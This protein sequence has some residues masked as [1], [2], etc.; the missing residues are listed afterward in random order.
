MSD[1][2][3]LEDFIEG[4]SE[5]EENKEDIIET[6]EWDWIPLSELIE[7]ILGKTPKRSEDQY[8]EE[9]DIKWASAKDIS[10]SY[11]RHIY[12][13][14]EK[15]T[16]AGKEA[17]NAK[18]MPEGTVVVTA[19]GTLGEVI[20]LGEP[21]TFNQSCYALRTN[22]ML[23]DDYLYYAWQYVFGQIEAISYGT[24]FDTITMKSF[25]DIEIPLPP[26]EIQRK[27]A[28]ALTGFDNKI[29]TNNRINELLEETAQSLYQHWFVNFKPYEDFK[30]SSLG[31]IPVEFEVKSLTEISDVTYGYG[32]DSDDFNEN[33]DGYPVIRNGDL[34]NKTV[35]NSTDKYLN[36]EFDSRYEVLPGDLIFTMDRYF[37][38]YLWRGERA[39]LNQRICKFE[40]ISKSH[41]NLFLYYLI[42]KPINRVEKAKTGT[43]LPHL[44]KGD[45]DN[46]DVIV[47]DSESLSDFNKL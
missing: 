39:A 22:D 14:E 20:Q 46:I 25:K 27:I 38:P 47:P 31:K 2:S 44:G 11:T 16:K 15:M 35:D 32:F 33:K 9:G 23:L 12:E 26:V 19:R 30:D 24:V 37:D 6:Q 40:G 45:I 13:T 18:I 36:K 41:S 3:N 10:Q 43:T 42:E 17:S 4:E 29:E 21:M 5:M 1:K 8:W 28:S 34:P 7:P